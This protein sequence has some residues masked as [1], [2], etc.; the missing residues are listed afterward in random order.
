MYV[1]DRGHLYK[2]ILCIIE[3]KREDT[4]VI[5][6]EGAFQLMEYMRV[7]RGH[8]HHVPLPSYLVCKDMY[9]RFE[10]LRGQISSVGGGS[11][12]FVNCDPPLPGSLGVE[13]S[14]LAIQF[15]NEY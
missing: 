14:R 1:D 8:T 10:V 2:K 4:E 13:L 9:Y 6:K 7:A 11:P 12:V 3:I 5:R 15:W